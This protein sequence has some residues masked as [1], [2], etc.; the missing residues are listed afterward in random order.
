MINDG[1]DSFAEQSTL[2]MKKLIVLRMLSL[3]STELCQT[4]QDITRYLD[5]AF[6]YFIFLH[7]S[8]YTLE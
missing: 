6:L 4:L 1:V 3:V 8:I 5:E 7:P 2:K